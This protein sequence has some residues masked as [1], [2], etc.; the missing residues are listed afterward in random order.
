M[1]LKEGLL[2]HIFRRRA[3]AQESDEEMEQLALIALHQLR[4]ALAISLAIRRQKILVAAFVHGSW[5]LERR[6]HHWPLC[7]IWR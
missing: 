6:R 1:N 3:I 4:E 5:L 2:K 7:R